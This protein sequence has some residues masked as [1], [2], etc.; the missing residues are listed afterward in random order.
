MDLDPTTRSPSPEVESL[1][2]QLERGFYGGAW[3]GPAL[4]EVL[5]GVDAETAC[6]RVCPEGKS[7]WE[8]VRH[9]AAWNSIA[10]RRIRGEEPEITGDQDWPPVTDTSAA[11]WKAAVAELET[12]HRHLY[13]TVRALEDAQ[14][15]DAVAGSDPTV[16]GLLLGTLQ[17]NSYH[18]GQIA[19]LKKGRP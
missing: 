9:L 4:Q 14:L 19:L 3:H 7:L 1:A 13:C 6:H 15:D 18:A 12:N 10:A 16:R 11:A 17:H 8:I 2:D 5:E